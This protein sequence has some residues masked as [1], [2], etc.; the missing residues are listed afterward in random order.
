MKELPIYPYVRPQE[1]DGAR[2]DPHPVAVVGAGL[3]GLTLA[4]DLVRRGIPVVVLDDDNTVGVRGLAS[5][6]MVWA[7]RTLDIFDRLGV[8]GDVVGKGVRWNVGRVLCRDM[9]VASFTLQDQPDMRHNGFVNLQQ[10]YLEAFLVDALMREPLADL[11]WLNRVAGIEPGADGPAALSVETPDGAYRCRA[12]WVAACDGASS[13][14]RGMLGLSPQVYDRTEDRWIIIDIVLRDTAWPEERWTWLDARSNHGRAVW[15]HKMAD[16]TWRLDFQ[17]RPDEDP[18][19]AATEAAMR[20]RVW[21]LLGEPVAFDIA[22]HGVWA[23]RH[24]CLDSLRHGRVLFAGD[25]AHLVAPFGARGG[26]GGI[27][28]AD[29]LGWKLALLLQG[30]ADESLLDT[31][32]AERKHAAMEN[33]RQARRSSR[34]VYPGE[35]CSGSAALWRDAI[36]ALAPRHEVAARMINT[37]RLCMPAVY[38][39]SPLARGPHAHAGRALPN[40]VLRQADGLTLHGLLGPWFTVLVFGDALPPGAPGAADGGS[41]VDWVAVGPLCDERG[42]AAL[43]H[44]LGLALDGQAWLLRPDQHV[45][46]AAAPDALGADEPQAW[47]AAALGDPRRACP[48]SFPEAGGL[49]PLTGGARDVAIPATA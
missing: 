3:T 26:N 9:A 4:L 32:S 31:Y 22:W 29:N 16:D 34:F 6:G 41:L 28:D 2:R 21:D 15:R 19:E 27:Q 18:A 14:V 20:Q 35:A 1:M 11:R 25:S 36:I 48:A 47:V 49:L 8:A 39:D 30:R 33:I 13:A 17:L 40:V 5:R 45:M 44:Q 10:Y 37:G 43:A 24:E 23:Y 12:Q 46:A 38:P 42:R 7:Q